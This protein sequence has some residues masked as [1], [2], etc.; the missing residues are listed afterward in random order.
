MK[1]K[2]LV[3]RLTFPE[4]IK[5]PT[6][7]AFSGD[8]AKR[9][10]A[11]Q[12][13]DFEG[14][15]VFWREGLFKFTYHNMELLEKGRAPIGKDGHPVTLHHLGG[16]LCMMSHRDHHIRYNEYLHNI[17][18]SKTDPD[19]IDKSI[20]QGLPSFWY[21]KPVFI[22]EPVNRSEFEP[23]KKRFWQ[24]FY[25]AITGQVPNHHENS[26]EKVGIEGSSSSSSKRKKQKGVSQNSTSQADSTLLKQLKQLKNQII[27]FRTLLAK[28]SADNSTLTG[29]QILEIQTALPLLEELKEELEAALKEK[30]HPRNKRSSFFADA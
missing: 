10:Y 30:Q 15:R 17:H 3:P 7:I 20:K 22:V 14:I 11:F 8:P 19:E 4:Y 5:K 1:L 12:P 18:P 9:K 27:Q 29:E 26:F 6:N 16:S 13:I 21:D 24:H 28:Q 2:G 25:Q 23:F